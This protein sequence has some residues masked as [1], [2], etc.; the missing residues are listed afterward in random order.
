ME[1]WRLAMTWTFSDRPASRRS[2]LK[3]L[4]RFAAALPLLDR[5]R[6]ATRQRVPRIG[7]MAGAE[8]SLIAS[9]DEEMRKLGYVPGKNIQVEVRI[10]ARMNPSDTATHA[11][12]LGAMDLDFVVAAA[13]PQ[14]LVMRQANPKMPMVIITCPG[15]V[16]NGFAASLDRPGGIYTGMDELPPGVTRKRLQLL[17][18]AA[19]SISRVALLSTTP[20]RGGHE[21]QAA[22]AEAAAK[23]FGLS[24]KVY[25]ATSVPEITAALEAIRSDRMDGLLNFQGGLSLAN[26]QLIVDFAAANRVAAVYQA[27]FFV[28]AGGLM[29]WA[30]DQREQYRMAARMADR[31]LKGTRPGDIPAQHPEPYQLHL[32]RRAAAAIGLTLP[33]DLIAEANK[34]LP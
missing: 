31:I 24:V 27:A 32:N 4:A 16:S 26:R 5:S 34:V 19:P 14:A 15:L 11:A 13:L 25:R 20:G 1:R 8:P 3:G 28:E 6:L 10:A 23:D 17:K 21:R 30:P 7:F 29:A 12:E 2:F 18:R 33:P 9:F 22:D